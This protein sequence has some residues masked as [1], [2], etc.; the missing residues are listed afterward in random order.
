[1]PEDL[2]Q[3]NPDAD[4]SPLMEQ[5]AS[6]D[7]G[8][9]FLE[10]IA[11]PDGISDEEITGLIELE[12]E[13]TAP[14][15]I[16]QLTWGW[17]AHPSRKSVFCYAAPRELLK[18]SGITGFDEISPLVPEFAAVALIETGSSFAVVHCGDYSVAIAYS[19][20]ATPTQAV[21][22]ET[23]SEELPNTLAEAFDLQTPPEP[24]QISSY[25]VDLDS[26]SEDLGCSWQLRDGISPDTTRQLSLNPNAMWLADLRDH[27]L[28]AARQKQLRTSSLLWRSV[29]YVA[30]FLL[31]LLGLEVAQWGLNK[32][33]GFRD[34]K[35]DAQTP[36]VSRLEQ[37]QSFLYKLEDI[38]KSQMRPFAVMAVLNDNRP[39]SIQFLRVE[40]TDSDTF[41]V[42][43]RGKTVN[44]VNAYIQQF[45][46]NNA[47]SS[48]AHDIRSTRPGAVDFEI[49]I[50]V[51]ALP[52][53]EPLSPSPQDSESSSA[54]EDV[55]GTTS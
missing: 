16:E 42:S 7:A 41:E 48:I 6:I 3:I 23:E 18:R 55:E 27:D 39:T 37:Q 34:G 2:N 8:L 51:N 46:G 26:S 13:N 32:F 10:W 25:R 11:L 29:T 9:F 22:I 36:I 50:T 35:L 49:A 40:A 12:I 21:A 4:D 31:V 44:E 43:A 38:E 19:S 52:P 1:M 30:V 20:D 45:V 14:F 28:K 17:I 24:G 15:P 5:P 33:L 47:F 53:I 54:D